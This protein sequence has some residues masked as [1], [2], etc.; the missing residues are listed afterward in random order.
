MPIKL[1][2]SYKKYDRQTKK[3]TLEHY[4]IKNISKDELFKDLNND[5]T[6]PKVKQKIRTELTRRGI[7]IQ[8]MPITANE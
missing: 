6:K 7:K 8:W 5:S 2:P 3:T 1:K 4:Y